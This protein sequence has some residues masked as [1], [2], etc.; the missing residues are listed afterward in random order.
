MKICTVN[1]PESYLNAIA[2]LVGD[3]GLYPSRSELIRASVREFIFRELQ[4]AHAFP[5]KDENNDM[6]RVPIQHAEKKDANMKEFK[7]YK[8]IKKLEF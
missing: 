4:I 7:T 6:V 8:I 1:V 5:M 3:D 2:K